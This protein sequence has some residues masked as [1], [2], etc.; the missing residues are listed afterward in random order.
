MLYLLDANVLIDANRDYYPIN[1]VVPEFWEWLIHMGES[2]QVKIPL[3]IYEE[4]KKGTDELQI[5]VKKEETKVALLLNEEVDI[6]VIRRVINDGYANDLTDSEIEQ[7]GQDPLLIAYALKDSNGRC[8]VTTEASKPKKQRANKHV[9]DVCDILGVSWC[10]TFEF[11]R[12]LG[13]ST[14][15]K[16]IK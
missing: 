1:H 11:I 15:W 3:D 7:V 5:W 13:F 2:N 12:T 14:N 6:S 16:A 8:L 9:P 4:L 10:H